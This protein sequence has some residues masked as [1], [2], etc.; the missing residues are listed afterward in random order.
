MAVRTPSR[1]GVPSLGFMVCPWLSRFTN[2]QIKGSL[3]SPDLG[4]IGFRGLGMG[5]FLYGK[6]R[7]MKRCLNSANHERVALNPGVQALSSSRFR[8]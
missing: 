8:V 2:R 4:S 1:I 5:L 7:A 6:A 3:Q